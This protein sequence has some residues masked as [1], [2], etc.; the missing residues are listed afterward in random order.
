M[1][2]GP[3]ARIFTA[4]W[5]KKETQIQGTFFIANCPTLIQKITLSCPLNIFLYVSVILLEQSYLTIS[6]KLN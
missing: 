6:T 5:P 4:D 1:T 3:I 2:I